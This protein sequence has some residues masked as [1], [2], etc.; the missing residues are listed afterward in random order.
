MDTPQ[1]QR[2]QQHTS[3]VQQNVVTQPQS[4]FPRQQQ[5]PIAQVQQSAIPQQ[6]QHRFT[7][8]RQVMVH[9]Q[10]RQQRGSFQAQQKVIHQPQNVFPQYQHH[11][12]AQP[13]QTMVHQHPE[14]P[15]R[16]LY[17]PPVEVEPGFYLAHS[18]ATQG[19]SHTREPVQNHG[20]GTIEPSEVDGSGQKTPGRSQFVNQQ[21]DATLK[22]SFQAVV[23]PRQA[24]SSTLDSH[25]E[26]AEIANEPH[27]LPHSISGTPPQ[28]RQDHSSSRIRTTSASLGALEANLRKMLNLGT[29]SSTERDKFDDLDADGNMVDTDD[30]S[31]FG[32]T[33]EMNPTA[34]ALAE[35][36]PS[37]TTATPPV[38]HTTVSIFTEAR[39]DVKRL[40]ADIEDLSDSSEDSPELAASGFE[41][42]RLSS[43]NEEHNDHTTNNAHGV[44]GADGR[45]PQELPTNAGE[46]ASSSVDSPAH[47]RSQLDDDNEDRARTEIGVSRKRTK[48]SNL[49]FI[50]C[51]H[52]GP[53]RRCSGT[54]DTISEVLRKLSEQHDTHVCDRCWVLKVKDE[55][56][57]LYAHPADGGECLDHC[58]SPQCHKSSSTT[59]QRH[60]FHQTTCGT[61]SSRVRPKDSEA[62]YRFIFCLVHP[63][64]DCPASVLTTEN[65]LHLDAVPRQSRRKPNKEELTARVNDLKKRLEAGESQNA[66]NADRIKQLEQALADANRAMIRDQD[67]NSELEKQTR[68]IVA[69]LSDALRTGVFLDTLDHQSLLRRVEEDAPGALVHQSQSL[70]T[71]SA[72][73]RSRNSSATP[74]RGDVAGQAQFSRPAAYE[75]SIRVAPLEKMPGD[76][77]MNDCMSA[78]LP[79]DPD[80]DPSWRDI[81]DEPGGG[82][83]IHP[84]I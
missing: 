64:L 23:D 71:P 67:K 6:Q 34:F 62:V 5:H 38:S 66:M 33:L 4:A 70:L 36:M 31:K 37:G 22:G 43:S 73:D 19:Y 75:G 55:S 35:R 42:M 40:Q 1:E 24:G 69:M 47:K 61:K 51:F 10:P 72:S 83:F 68:R 56:S 77:S 58:L 63:Q 49:R 17:Q 79:I 25:Q 16:Q 20:F 74:V 53:G 41:A 12:L 84:Q 13:Q 54:D 21:V 11:L 2:Q 39:E 82:N 60:L 15:Q 46:T 76:R 52:N 57:G 65:T 29:G 81:F 45:K 32:S 28:H 44:T 59:G 48:L 7:Q 50:C 80:M 8:P 18:P 3:Q 14:Q 30:E 78:T 26:Q 9:Q 27:V